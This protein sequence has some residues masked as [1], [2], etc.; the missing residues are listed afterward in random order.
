MPRRFSRKIF[1]FVVLAILAL[2]WV[3]AAGP[4]QEEVRPVV[5][6]SELLGRLW[7]LV[8]GVWSADGCRIDPSGCTPE[9]PPLDGVDS[10]CH[11]DPNG[12]C[13]A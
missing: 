12:G 7:D 9:P 1:V 13:G 8:T 5:S 3:S 4:R 2:P 6:V 10:G 11:I